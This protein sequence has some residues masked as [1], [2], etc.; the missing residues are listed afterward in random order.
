MAFPVIPQH[1]QLEK[2]Q[3]AAAQQPNSCPLLFQ[4]HR[5]TYGNT[6]EPLLEN[7]T[8]EYDLELFRRAQ[9]RASED[10]VR[11]IP[12]ALP[13]EPLGQGGPSRGLW[14]L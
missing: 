14:D 13:A 4:E 8:S 2:L 11:S 9:A 3:D 1:S 6:R 5:Q 10:L 7:L 12:E